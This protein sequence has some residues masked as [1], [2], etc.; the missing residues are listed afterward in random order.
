MY[1]L[2]K[3]EFGLEKY[4]KVKSVLDDLIA[5]NP[6][7]KNA[8]AHLLYARAAE[9]NN[10]TELALQEYEVLDGYYPGPEATYRYAILLKKVGR[11]DET[12]FLLEKILHGSKTS[13]KHYNSLHKEW[14]AKAKKE[15]QS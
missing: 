11:H 1:G 5:H 14:I 7:F 3:A 2:A 12:R 6:D 9:E 13:N 10:E 15:Y 8:D 4:S